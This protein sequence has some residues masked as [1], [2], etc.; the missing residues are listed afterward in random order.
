MHGRMRKLSMAVLNTGAESNNKDIRNACKKALDL[1]AQGPAR[2]PK[3]R[4]KS[5]EKKFEIKEYRPRR[6]KKKRKMRI[7]HTSPREMGYNSR[8]NFNR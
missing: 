2:K 5:K 6:K 8:Q 4:K 3:K 1:I 7:S